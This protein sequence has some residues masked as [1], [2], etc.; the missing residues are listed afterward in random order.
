[1]NRFRVVV[2]LIALLAVGVLLTAQRCDK[3]RPPGTLELR[4]VIE[5]GAECPMLVTKD[6]RRF[7]LAGDLQ[8]FKPGD[9]VCVSGTRA[10]VSYCMA[11]EATVAVERI[12]AGKEC[13]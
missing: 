1:M 9:D 8:G 11:G 6:G 3:S 13:D 10:E 7:S 2:R 5:P 4:G 12:V